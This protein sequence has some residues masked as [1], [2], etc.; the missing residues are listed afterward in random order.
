M[1]L[2][3]YNESG[4]ALDVQVS[5]Q[6]E[7]YL[8]QKQMCEL[9]GLKQ[10]N[11][12]RSLLGMQEDG[13]LDS[14]TC[15]SLM[16]VATDGK[17]RQIAHYPLEA[18]IY[19]GMRSRSG[20]AIYFQRWALN[21]LKETLMDKKEAPIPEQEAKVVGV[22]YLLDWAVE[23]NLNVGRCRVLAREGLFSRAYK[24]RAGDHERWLVKLPAEVPSVYYGPL[25]GGAGHGEFSTPQK[26]LAALPTLV[27]ELRKLQEVRQLQIGGGSE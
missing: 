25:G 22:M 17:Q 26:A 5:E 3:K 6:G 20:K 15:I 13:L 11:V 19:V 4:I 27:R 8:T 2:A 10:Q 12:S 14:S 1:K 9:Y 21:V 23:R 16:C 7:V 18:T 24:R